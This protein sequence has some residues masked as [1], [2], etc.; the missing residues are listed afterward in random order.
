MTAE[1]E[2]LNKKIKKHIGDY[3]RADEKLFNFGIELGRLLE[4]N[5]IKEHRLDFFIE[6]E[7]NENQTEAKRERIDSVNKI[8][9]NLI[10]WAHKEQFRESGSIHYETGWHS[11]NKPLSDE[12]ESK[13]HINYTRINQNNVGED[14]D[15]YFK[16]NGKLKDIFDNHKIGIEVEISLSNSSEEEEEYINSEDDAENG[17]YGTQISLY[18]HQDKKSVSEIDA[19]ASDVENFYTMFCLKL[20]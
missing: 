1:F 14:F 16:L 15:I 7:N 20:T 12:I 18:A 13:Y 2:K 17:F 19:F 6:Q 11:S 3:R 4:K 8:L 5:K 9:S 10:K